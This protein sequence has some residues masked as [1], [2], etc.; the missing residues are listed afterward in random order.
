MSYFATPAEFVKLPCKHAV[1]LVEEIEMGASCAIKCFTW[2]PSNQAPRAG[3][4]CIH[5]L[6]L[7]GGT[8]KIFGERMSELGIA[9]YALDVRGCGSWQ[10]SK[11][12]CTLSLGECT[13]DVLSLLQTIR[14]KHPNIPFF[15]LGESL[16]SA[17]AVAAA[18][19]KSTPIDGLILSAPARVAHDHKRELA[20]LAL[21]AL[22]N[23]GRPMCISSAV[24]RFAPEV[25]SWHQSD[26]LIRLRFT[27]PELLHLAQ[28]LVASFQCLPKLP[29]IPV[30]VVQGHTDELIRTPRTLTYFDRLPCKDK[31]LLVLGNAG[32]LIFATRNLSPQLTS[33][34]G[35][36]INDRLHATKSA[37]SQT[38]RRRAG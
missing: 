4:L 20:D 24:F 12:A 17:I 33:I 5:G 36:W 25:M 10:A 1:S 38:Q 19:R 8:F 6:G 3:L 30:L 21:Q 11:S 31:Q 34:V 23:L 2:A 28:F 29:D 18:V 9:T 13:S 32:H 15:V 22:T 16:G 26:P 14:E 27:V 37:G 35:T 7:H